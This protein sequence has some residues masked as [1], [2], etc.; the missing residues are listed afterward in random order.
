[1]RA[2]SQLGYVLRRLVLRVLRLRT[3]GVKVMLFNEANQ[4]LLIR[5]AYGDSRQFL[6]PGGG[7]SRRES[8]AAAAIREIREE[9][10]LQLDSVEPVWS[11]ES[12]AE[13]KRDTIHLFR[14]NIS[15]RP[16]ADGREVIEARFFALGALPSQVSPATL[17]RIAEVSGERPIDGRW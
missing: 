8:P 3:C 7:V 16:T 10:G 9:L 17:R 14:A 2:F 15:D 11:Y 12:N 5:N 4:L 6:L 13:G 1:M